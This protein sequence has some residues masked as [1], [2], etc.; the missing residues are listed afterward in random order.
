MRETAVDV[1]VYLFENYIDQP[2][3]WETLQADDAFDISVELTQAGFDESTVELALDW[4][5]QLPEQ[6]PASTTYHP[7]QHQS[8]RIYTDEEQNLLGNDCLNFLMEMERAKLMDGQQR[9]AV[10][11]RVSALD[12]QSVDLEQFKWLICLVLFNTSD[13][14]N[15]EQQ[16]RLDELEDWMYAADGQVAH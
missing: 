7:P 11:D 9:E 14:N 15:A 2:Q 8:I 5:E 3:F 4:L 6:T 13:D 1:L 12:A 10:L 16:S